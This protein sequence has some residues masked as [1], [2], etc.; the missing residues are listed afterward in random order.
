M[1]H[2]Y[3][4]FSKNTCQ[5]SM[6]NV[7]DKDK[8]LWYVMRVY[9]NENNLEILTSEAGLEELMNKYSKRDAIN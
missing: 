1:N 3:V 2:E 4:L 6:V 9:K 7:L 8:I 5:N